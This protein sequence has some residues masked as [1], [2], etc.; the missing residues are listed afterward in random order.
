[1]GE[2]TRRDLQDL[3]ERLI[4]AI[5]DGQTKLLR[6]FYGFTQTIQ[7]RFKE[8][9]D[10]DSALRD[11]DSALKRRMG[12]LESRVLEIEKRLNLPPAAA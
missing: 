6:A 9:D 8:F 1:M 10:T 7:E 12:A 5:R 3:E 4:E 2:A 11:A